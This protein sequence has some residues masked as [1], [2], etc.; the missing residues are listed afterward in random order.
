MRDNTKY[1]F[2]SQY[3]QHNL[4]PIY[5][6][7]LLKSKSNSGST[8]NAVTKIYNYSDNITAVSFQDKRRLCDVEVEN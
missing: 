1:K 5:I 3:R 8:I 2:K 6:V 4:G 7:Y